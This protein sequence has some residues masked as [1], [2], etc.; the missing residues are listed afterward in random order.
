[1]L[2]DVCWDIKVFLFIFFLV[3]IAFSEAFLRI[4]ETSEK[5]IWTANYADTL[6]YTFYLSLGNILLEGYNETI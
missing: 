3:V 2:T 4:I 5:G 6:A 1:M